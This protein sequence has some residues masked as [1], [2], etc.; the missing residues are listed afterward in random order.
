MEFLEVEA[1]LYLVPLKYFLERSLVVV[2]G[3]GITLGL[4][5]GVSEVSMEEEEVE[6]FKG[7]EAY[8]LVL[9]EL[10]GHLLCKK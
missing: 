8:N 6:M 5:I 3:R 9:A 1:S 2:K 7:G 10:K 4:E